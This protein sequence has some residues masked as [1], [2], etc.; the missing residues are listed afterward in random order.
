MIAGGFAGLVLL[1]A[2]L[3][4]QGRGHGKGK[5]NG[6]DV[7][8]GHLP[9]ANMCRVW[10]DGVPPGHQPAPTDC[11]TAR[12][13]RPSNAR[14]IYG[15]GARERDRY[16]RDRAEDRDRDRYEDRRDRDRDDVYRRRE[17][18]GDVYRR[19]DRGDRTT[20]NRGGYPS[21]L[22]MMRSA[23]LY[24]LGVRTPDVS[25]WLGSGSYSAQI[26]EQGG[27]MSQV[28]WYVKGGDL[29]QVWHDDDRDGRVD[30]VEVVQNGRVVRVLR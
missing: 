23:S 7:P 28:R 18:R 21:Q 25:S 17:D 2:P 22:P 29:V 11:R 20:T 15:S 16:D 30:R 6:R 1:V 3:A 4:A 12:R 19:G 26:D 10:I 8:P 24:R 14:I 27:R 13:T 5:G 9:P